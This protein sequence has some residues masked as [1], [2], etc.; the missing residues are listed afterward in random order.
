LHAVRRL[1]ETPARALDARPFDEA[2]RR[3][4]DLA[5]EDARE[6]PLAHRHLRG[7]GGDRQIRVEVIGD[8]RLQLAQRL[9][10][11]RLH[12]ELGT[13]L[14]LPAGALDRKSTRL[15][16]SHGSISYAVFC[17]K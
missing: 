1:L 11:C 3:E 16:S 6:V 14:R 12:G 10:V 4:T 5:R 17:L 7:E 13:E 8:P 15:N 2:R 9:A